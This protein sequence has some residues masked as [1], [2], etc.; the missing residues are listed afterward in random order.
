[1]RNDSMRE[2][3]GAHGGRGPWPWW[4]ERIKEQRN[5][6]KSESCRYTKRLEQ[7]VD[8]PYTKLVGSL[9]YL[10]LKARGT[11]RQVSFRV[12]PNPRRKA[13]CTRAQ[14]D[15]RIREISPWRINRSCA[16]RRWALAG[17]SCRR[18]RRLLAWRRHSLAGRSC[19]WSSRS[20]WSGSTE[21]GWWAR[22]EER[23]SARMKV[24]LG[25]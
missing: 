16:G 20:G 2:A 22:G 24:H 5:T 15:R 1:M 4:L 6:V 17:T 21:A 23:A 25:P 13:E 3:G 10:E 7:I 11:A 9:E 18:S 12:R 14:E 19:R 8:N